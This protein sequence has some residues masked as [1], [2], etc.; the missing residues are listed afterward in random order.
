MDSQMWSNLIAALAF[1]VSITAAVFSWRTAAHAKL[2]N[3]IAIHQYQKEIYQAFF[4]VRKLLSSRALYMQN[5]ELRP[6]GLVFKS[7]ALYVSG[8]LSTQL[9]A[10]YDECFKIED[11]HNRLE[12]DRDYFRLLA[13]E[14]VELAASELEESRAN[15]EKE[16]ENSRAN[17]LECLEIAAELAK[18]VDD[19]FASEIT[20][21]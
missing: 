13:N 4:E 6:F 18:K 17:L 20:L 8:A 11:F 2:A 19:R 9:L 7:S 16:V 5:D 15:A 10:F 14:P 21:K 1:V 3:N 12:V